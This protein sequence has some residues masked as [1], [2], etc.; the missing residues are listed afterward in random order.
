M[1]ALPRLRLQPCEERDIAQEIIRLEAATRELLSRDPTAAA[2]LAKRPTRQRRTRAEAVDRLKAALDAAK[3]S[4]DAHGPT[5]AEADAKWE[6]AQQLRWRLAMSAVR[7]VRREARR[8]SGNGVL[9]ERD[10]TQEGL[11]GLLA[12]AKRYE[13][14]RDVRFATYARW[15]VRAE[16]T[17]AIELSRL[18]RM[19]AAACEQLRNMR[20]QIRHLESRGESWSVSDIAGS[21]GIETERARQLLAAVAAQPLDDRGDDDSQPLVSSLV[22]ESLPAP[23]DVV[24]DRELIERLLTALN[25]SLTDPQRR[26]LIR[27]FGIGVEPCTLAEIARGMSLSRER[28]RQLERQSLKLLREAY[29]AAV[30]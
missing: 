23:D 2:V 8:L 7:I 18:V 21:L 27:R 26:I 13:A 24:A 28:V 20:K 17:R 4:P 11:I 6:E 15:W 22:D 5:I 25:N 9:S 1:T 3:Q 10:L 19:S 29:E 12:A 16:M 14:G 30:A